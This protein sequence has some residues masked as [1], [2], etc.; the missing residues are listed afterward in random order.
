[1][2]PNKTTRDRGRNGALGAFEHQGTFTTG[3][4]GAHLGGQALHPV[5]DSFSFAACSKINPRV[6]ELDRGKVQTLQPAFLYG[7][8][9]K[10]GPVVTELG[11]HRVIVD[12]IASIV[13]DGLST[14]D[15]HPLKYVRTVTV[16]DVYPPIYDGTGKP[17]EG[18]FGPLH[19]IRAPMVGE[20]D[21]VY[22]HFANV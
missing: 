17:A 19:H 2:S 12:K 1:M 8:L 7:K 21:R 11:V 22:P 18:L 20:Y 9:E 3:K 15:L 10:K 14:V 16:I 4:V 6:R 5:Q 13:K